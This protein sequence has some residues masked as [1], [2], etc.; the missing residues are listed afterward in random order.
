[1]KFD[2]LFKKFYE[3]KMADIFINKFS[4]VDLMKLN[5]G[6]KMNNKCDLVVST[7]LYTQWPVLSSKQGHILE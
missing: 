5:F 7:N 6:Q 3:T 2:Q 4:A 1:M